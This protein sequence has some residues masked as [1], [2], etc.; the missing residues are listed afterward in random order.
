MY[1]LME[2]SVYSRNV[3]NLECLFL[4][5]RAVDVNM[6]MQTC[7]CSYVNDIAQLVN[8]TASAEVPP[9]IELP[10]ASPMYSWQCCGLRSSNSPGAPRLTA[11]VSNLSTQCHR[12]RVGIAL[13]KLQ[14]K[15]VGCLSQWDLQFQNSSLDVKRHSG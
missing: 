5:P 10:P 9:T 6:A 12:N 7:G 8:N 3:Y 2:S 4:Y 13:C 1:E 11:T 15:F 14:S